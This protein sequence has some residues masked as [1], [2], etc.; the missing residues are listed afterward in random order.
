MAIPAVHATRAA[1]LEHV[2][3]VIGLEPDVQAYLRTDLRI[4]S[5]AHLAGSM[6]KMFPQAL[7]L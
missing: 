3:N 4:T 6:E 1:R 5:L 2:F 7:L